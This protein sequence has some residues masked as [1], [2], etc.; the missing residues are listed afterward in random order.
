ML[1]LGSFCTAQ[2]ST[3]TNKFLLCIH[4]QP[5]SHKSLSL[6]GKYYFLGK[7]NILRV[8]NKPNQTS[9]D[10]TNT[11]GFPHLLAQTKNRNAKVVWGWQQQR[12][13]KIGDK[14]NLASK[15]SFDS[16]IQINLTKRQ[17][18]RKSNKMIKVD[19]YHS[20]HAA[21]V[22]VTARCG[23]SDQTGGEG[24]QQS[25]AGS[26]Q[27]QGQELTGLRR[28]LTTPGD[29]SVNIQDRTY[30]GVK[31]PVYHFPAWQL[32]YKINPDSRLTE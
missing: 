3:F 8:K 31:G 28:V 21:S 22:Q 10:L 15:N 2:C 19:L 20:L 32:I 25:V 23:D 24:Q 29:R 18:E 27:C 1:I 11:H 7:T 9:C 17:W 14:T 16:C 5:S 13:E 30:G 12:E 4:I 26:V 6:Q